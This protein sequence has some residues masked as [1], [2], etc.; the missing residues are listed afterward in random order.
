[1][2]CMGGVLGWPMTDAPAARAPPREF[3]PGQPFVAASGRLALDPRAADFVQVA[4]GWAPPAASAHT[5]SAATGT[6]DATAGSGGR[7]GSERWSEFD[8]W[9]GGDFRPEG[10]SGGGGMQ[11]PGGAIGGYEQQAGTGGFPA[12]AAAYG[13]QLQADAGVSWGTH[14]EQGVAQGWWELDC[15]PHA[16]G[17]A[18]NGSPVPPV[19]AVAC[20][21]VQEIIWTAN[22][23]GWVASLSADQSV[24]RRQHAAPPQL[25]TSVRAHAQSVHGLC[26]SRFGVLSIS[27]SRVTFHNRGGMLKHE[28]GKAQKLE[29]LR[30][31]CFGERDSCFVA[32]NINRL[33][34]ISLGK[35]QL[36]R[37]VPLDAGV[38]ALRSCRS[39]VVC[40]GSDGVVTMRDTRQLKATQ[41][42]QA[43]S[44][45]V[46]D[47]DVQGHILVTCGYQKRFDRS[48]QAM[49][50]AE[51][52]FINVYDIRTHRQQLSQIPCPYGPYQLRFHPNFTS[53]VFVLSSAGVFQQC[54]VQDLSGHS[55]DIH[56]YPIQSDGDCV[57]AFDV[58]KSAEVLVFG[59]SGGF[60]HRW[61]DRQPFRMNPTAEPVEHVDRHPGPPAFQLELDDLDSSLPVV[62]LAAQDDAALLSNMR[63]GDWKQNKVAQPPRTIEPDLLARVELR[64]TIGVIDPVP[65]GFVRNST[66]GSLTW[67]HVSRAEAKAA[68]QAFSPGAVS[69][70][71]DGTPPVHATRFGSA[72]AGAARFGP[73]KLFSP[74][75][76]A[77]MR[78]DTY[79]RVNLKI[80]QLEGIQGFD[81]ARYNRTALSGL[82]NGLPNSYT[83]PIL[84]L[85]YYTPALR[86]TMLNRLSKE[87]VCLCDEL[88]FLFAM[89]DESTLACFPNNFLRAFRQLRPPLNL[90]ASED[91]EA[92]MDDKTKVTRIINCLQYL[93]EHLHKELLPSSS[94]A[95][96]SSVSLRSGDNSQPKADA[97]AQRSKVQKAHAYQ[98]TVVGKLY[99][100]KILTIYTE[101]KASITWTREDSAF[102]H[103]LVYPTPSQESGCRSCFCD[104]LERSLCKQTSLRT[105]VPVDKGGSETP[106]RVLQKKVLAELPPTLL[107]NCGFPTA[108]DSTSSHLKWLRSMESMKEDPDA[109][110]QAKPF[111]MCPTVQICLDQQSMALTVSEPDPESNAQPQTASEPGSEPEPLPASDSQQ[112]LEMVSSIEHQPGQKTYDLTAILCLVHDPMKKKSSQGGNIVAIVKVPKAQLKGNS[113][114]WLVFNDFRVEPV[115][116]HE[117][118]QLCGTWKVPLLLSY[119]RRDCMQLVPIPETINHRHTLTTYMAEFT[120][121]IN[122]SMHERVYSFTPPTRDELDRGELFVGIDAEFVALSHEVSSTREDGSR[123]TIIPA[124]FGLAR[125]SIVRGDPGPLE[126]VPIM[127]L[128]ISSPEPVADYL[129]QFSGVQPGDLD[130][131]VSRHFVTNLKAAYLQIM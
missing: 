51:D 80:K 2:G 91:A 129:T 92:S 13:A 97:D 44:H 95:A 98:S 49:G 121:S 26:A 48:T 54:D 59:D 19:T 16:C 107:V 31:A 93:L 122:R 25:Y 39:S 17:G 11:A 94:G 125:V 45:S 72:R 60:I 75:Q 12:A 35:G 28:W 70:A 61:V 102:L 79:A 68:L 37:D 115:S 119:T 10:A 52:R 47:L 42:L 7:V 71:A 33:L 73:S 65:D 89:M 29:Q 63:Y 50:A 57:N 106:Q 118:L 5:G 46:L 86:V 123:V 14:A 32:G 3:V 40:G 114:E 90:V 131:A 36:L 9:T 20:D 18:P 120:A 85:L 22:A 124:R 77:K 104:V 111:L 24:T 23:E 21:T 101:P 110:N 108:A 27:D 84:Q 76:A 88:N 78:H 43:H 112:N 81:F 99:S 109:S 34:Q 41:S 128:Y 116:Q 15:T 83:N 58:S 53:T 96:S 6:N 113:S 126:G 117:A 100:A 82:E 64:D 103:S 130:P 105:Y 4:A 8:G 87:E 62:Q 55:E 30:A 69:M 38:T 67:K 1:M 56:S 66:M 127:D 74:G